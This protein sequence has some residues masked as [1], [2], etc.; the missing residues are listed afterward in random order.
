MEIINLKYQIN[1]IFRESIEHNTLATKSVI[2]LCK[3]M[4]AL[5]CFVH[6]STAY[7]NCQLNEIDEKIY[8]ISTDPNTIIQASK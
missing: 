7:S 2:D 6:V 1:F 5:L 3:E 8:P 4:K